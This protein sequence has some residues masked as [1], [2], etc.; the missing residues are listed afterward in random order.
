MSV[1]D[2]LST[3]RYRG[4][5]LT[6]GGPLDIGAGGWKQSFGPDLYARLGMGVEDE[7]RRGAE[8]ERLAFSEGAAGASMA[9][10]RRLRETL[11]ANGVNPTQAGFIMA[12][13]GQQ[14]STM[15]GGQLAGSRARESGAVASNL[16]GVGD[17]MQRSVDYQDQLDQTEYWNQL[18]YKQMKK[19]N[20]LGALGGLLNLGL[21]GMGLFGAA[22]KGPLAGL[23]QGGGGGGGPQQQ[24]YGPPA[25]N[26]YAGGGYGGYNGAYVGGG[27]PYGPP[28][29]GGY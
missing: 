16:A 19:K 25:P 8:Q 7:I 10:E 18:M 28:E 11:G 1:R 22:G 13:Q 21:Q 2:F 4:R 24:T 14:L 27:Q 5:D 12:E 3:V 26:P 29:Y 23:L 6:G 17:A 20:R 9:N 15:L